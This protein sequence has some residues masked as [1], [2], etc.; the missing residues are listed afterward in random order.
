LF[1]FPFAIAGCT[2]ITNPNS[3]ATFNAS[4]TYM[5]VGFQLPANKTLNTVRMV[6]WDKV[7]TLNNTDLTVSVVGSSG[8]T[9]IPN[10]TSVLETRNTPDINLNS[11]VSGSPVVGVT[12]FSTPLAS[13]TPYWIWI[14][15]ANPTPSTNYFR[16]VY[17]INPARMQYVGTGTWGYNVLTSTNGGN[18]WSYY[19]GNWPLQLIFSDGTVLG[20]MYYHTNLGLTVT[21]SSMKVGMQFT[22]PANARLRVAGIGVVLVHGGTAPSGRICLARV[23]DG[24]VLGY[25]MT[26]RLIG[27]P[28]RYIGYWLN[29]VVEL[30]PST[31]YRVY[32][33]YIGGTVNASNYFGFRFNNVLATT[34]NLANLP[35]GGT[36][37]LCYSNDGGSTWTTSY[38]LPAMVLALD[39]ERPFAVM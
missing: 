12:G 6:W 30:Q 35:F 20:L 34:E 39:F 37:R 18:S 17:N 4:G 28:E 36:V 15:N 32:L 5:C 19:P 16:V 25:T 7:G 29:D 10:L 11:W 8:N 3:N 24:A 22:T 33:E 21:A 31:E 27:A 14:R 26:E 2:Q 9:N 38:G 13:G 1:Q 23:S